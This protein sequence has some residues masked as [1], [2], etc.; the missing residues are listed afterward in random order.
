MKMKK[1]IFP[2]IVAIIMTGSKKDPIPGPPTT[3]SDVRV[4]LAA[5]GPGSIS[6]TGVETVTAGTDVSYTVTPNTG[7]IVSSITMDGTAVPVSGS[8]Y[9]LPKVTTNHTITVVFAAV[10]AT[11]YTV[12]GTSGPNGSVTPSSTSVVSGGSVPMTFTPN[13]GFHTDSLWIDGVFVKTLAGVTTY[14][15]SNVTANHAVKVSF[16]DALKASQLDSL[17]N[18]LIGKKWCDIADSSKAQSSAN[19]FSWEVVEIPTC[20][21]DAYTVFLPGGIFQEYAGK[22]PCS[23]VALKT[24][25]YAITPNGKQVISKVGNQTYIADVVIISNKE[26]VSI[27]RNYSPHLDFYSKSVPLP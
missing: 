26:L 4:T 22:N 13:T 19:L 12:T 10:T 21:A 18:I 15:L 7:A 27:V 6:P 17:N 5:T 9:L 24:G 20:A 25:T 2:F 23:G 16:S 3:S 8:S 11:S 14:T 1:F